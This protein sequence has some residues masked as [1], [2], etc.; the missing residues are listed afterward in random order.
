MVAGATWPVVA[1]FDRASRQCS[2]RMG[3]LTIEDRGQGIKEALQNIHIATKFTR[4]G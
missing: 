2:S 1:L 3:K 4:I